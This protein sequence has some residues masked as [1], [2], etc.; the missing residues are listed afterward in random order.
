ML[1]H[2]LFANGGVENFI[3]M[4][5]GALQGG[6]FKFEVLTAARFV[7]E[8]FRSSLTE[9][10]IQTYELK[11]NKENFIKGCVDTANRLPEFMRDRNYDMIHLHSCSA[12]QS[13]LIVALLWRL[14]VRNIVLHSH[15]SIVGMKGI[16]RIKN[17]VKMPVSKLLLSHCE[18]YGL[19]PSMSAAEYMFPK[20]ML[21][22][23]FDIVPNAINA[24]RFRFNTA[25]RAKT[26][27]KLGIDDSC[28]LVGNVGRFSP[29]KNHYFILEI[30]RAIHKKCPDS[31]LLLVGEG[32]LERDIRQ[33]ATDLGL[34]DC[35]IVYGT[36]DKPENLYQAMDVFLFPSLFE[37]L[38]IVAI[39]AQA[40]GLPVIAS[41]T[42]PTEITITGQVVWKSLSETAE[43]WA[44]AVLA[45][46]GTARRDVYNDILRHG[47]DT[48][49]F[50]EKM[51]TC[52]L[53]ILGKGE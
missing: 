11:K 47:Y 39:E 45:A 38:G 40:A 30:F 44:N 12:I 24:D 5:C 9:L 31:R 28:F 25:L 49:A 29:Q 8:G 10:D 33:R 6:N 2:D 43:T 27:G 7:N 13:G 1:H 14:G 36:T 26:R 19:A 18:V 32:E 35:I 50:A 20:V 16:S 21:N 34:E 48:V 46:R 53:K 22:H 37:G 4:L 41:T 3:Y 42:V 23:R 51:R 17:I 52:Y 15:L